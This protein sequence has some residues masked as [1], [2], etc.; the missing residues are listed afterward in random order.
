[1]RRQHGLQ[2]PLDPHQVRFASWECGRGFDVGLL[3]Y[4]AGPFLRRLW[5]PCGRVLRLL[6]PIHPGPGRKDSPG[7]DLWHNRLHRAHIG[8]FDKVQYVSLNP[9]QH[10]SMSPAED[11]ATAGRQWDG[12][13]SIAQMHNIS[14]N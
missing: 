1:M 6:R 14:H 12:H 10:V 11:G 13:P 5:L 2:M 8:V 9:M 3:F 7:C 4:I